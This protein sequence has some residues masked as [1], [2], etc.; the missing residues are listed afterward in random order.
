[1][2]VSERLF[3]AAWLIEY[4]FFHHPSSL[5]TTPRQARF[6]GGTRRSHGEEIFMIC[7]EIPANHKLSAAELQKN[8]TVWA[9][10]KSKSKT[11]ERYSFPPEGLSVFWSA[12]CHGGQKDILFPCFSV[13][14]KR[15]KR[16]GG[17]LYLDKNP[18]RVNIQATL[19]RG[20]CWLT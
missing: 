12:V 18:F 8:C 14:L 7:R 15:V 13:F 10:D 5:S 2:R 20:G 1:M 3:L 9:D 16:A 6:A 19:F 4:D 11:W 17:K